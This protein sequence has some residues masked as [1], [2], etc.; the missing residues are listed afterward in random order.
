M[1]NLYVV[2]EAD[3]VYL[4]QQTGLTHGNINT[5][6]TRLQAGGYVAVEKMFVANRP[7]TVYRITE[8]GRAALQQYR[9]Q[10][11]NLLAQIDPSAPT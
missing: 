3:F 4:A 7:R 6:M 1:A 8:E 5:H 2:D 10:V 11:G 9:E